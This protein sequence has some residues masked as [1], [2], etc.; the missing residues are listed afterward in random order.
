[1]LIIYMTESNGFG[2]TLLG[3]YHLYFNIDISDRLEGTGEVFDDV[4]R[5]A[6]K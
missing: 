5:Q 4:I 6:S 3:R 1:M 2:K